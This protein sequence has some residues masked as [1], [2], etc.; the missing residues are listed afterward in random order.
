M[1]FKHILL[2][3]ILLRHIVL[4]SALQ[5]QEMPFQRPK[6][7]NISGGGYAPGPPRI[8][9]SLWPPPH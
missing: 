1:D 5:M 9:L 6:F 4:I 8:V 3:H 7:E 2:R